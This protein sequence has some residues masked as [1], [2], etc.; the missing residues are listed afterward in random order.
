MITNYANLKQTS[1]LTPITKSKLTTH[2][3]PTATLLFMKSV[4]NNN[5]EEEEFEIKAPEGNVVKYFSFA[6]SGKQLCLSLIE[7]N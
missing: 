1:P 5:K 4:V 2:V 6:T 3:L 7:I